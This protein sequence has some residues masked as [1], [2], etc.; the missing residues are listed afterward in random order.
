[1]G[2]TAAP[3]GS[4]TALTRSKRTD[5][6]NQSMRDGIWTAVINRG[7]GPIGSSRKPGGCSME[8]PDEP[9]RGTW[10]D[11]IGKGSRCGG[12]D[13]SQI[14]I[15]GLEEGF[16]ALFCDGWDLGDRCAIDAQPRGHVHGWLRIMQCASFLRGST[17]PQVQRGGVEP[18]GGP[19]QVLNWRVVLVA[20]CI[21]EI[22]WSN[23]SLD[24]TS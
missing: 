1:M 17:A 8:Q 19:G 12:M 16:T 13:D 3:K 4:E 21:Q 15:D 10:A 6:L 24:S 23:D 11:G 20:G 5:T 18:R 14:L 2:G 7:V 9:P 22:I